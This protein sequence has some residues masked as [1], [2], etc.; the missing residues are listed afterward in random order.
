MAIN[1]SLPWLAATASAT[2]LLLSLF[3]IWPWGYHVLLSYVVGITAIVMLVRAE[4]A[5]A[6]QWMIVW[7]LVAIIYNPIVPLHIPWGARQVMNALCSA[8]FVAGMRRL[9]L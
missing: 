5:G 1:R 2:L 6:R 3:P 7:I 9:R 4:Q 8:L